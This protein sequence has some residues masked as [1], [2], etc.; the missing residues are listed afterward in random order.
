MCIRKK[1]EIKVRRE[2]P[3]VADFFSTLPLRSR[4]ADWES[5][6]MMDFEIQFDRHSRIPGGCPFRI[7]RSGDQPDS[8]RSE[9]EDG[10]AACFQAS[11][12]RAPKHWENLYPVREDDATDRVFRT[13]FQRIRQRRTEF[14]DGSDSETVAAD[15]GVG[16]RNALFR[17]YCRSGSA[18][19]SPGCAEGLAVVDLRRAFERV[20]SERYRGL[21]GNNASVTQ[22]IAFPEQVALTREEQALIAERRQGDRKR[23]ASISE[24]NRTACRC[25]VSQPTYPTRRSPG[26]LRE[27]L[28]ELRE[29]GACTDEKR[30]E[31]MAAILARRGA[32][33]GRGSRRRRC[34]AVARGVVRMRFV[35]LHAGRGF[36]A[37]Y[38]TDEEIA[39]RFNA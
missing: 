17:E 6:P 25:S 20:L 28:A 21:L 31:R 29:T 27:L 38:I 4:K 36:C 37:G 26:T 10:G 24:R 1:T 32:L 14:I 30:H 34:R 39:G 19:A 11:D 12:N 7:P 3:S 8:I 23:W 13:A 15:A 2:Q 9:E 5:L 16:C 33:A 18:I 35:Q 22:L